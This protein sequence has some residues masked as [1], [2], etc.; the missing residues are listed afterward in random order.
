MP[1]TQADK[2]REDERRAKTTYD[3]FR[4]RLEKLERNIEKPVLI[5]ERP[6]EKGPA[7]PP[8]FVRN[9]VGSSAAAGS[10]DFH[11]FRNNRKRENDRLDWLEKQDKK[12]KMDEEYEERISEKQRLAEERTNKKRAKRLRKKER[13]KQR[14]KSGKAKQTED[15]D[16]DE[17]DSDSDNDGASPAP[18]K[19][20]P[21]GN[22]PAS[23]AG[24][25]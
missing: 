6:I 13:E 15:S 1:R 22:E 10:A 19:S 4:V 2:E 21:T 11:I 17:S 5:P 24:D 3:L 25:K 9:V 16:S 14:K 7:P 18:E 23:K 8:D 12:S 20:S